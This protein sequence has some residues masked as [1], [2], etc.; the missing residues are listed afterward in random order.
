MATEKDAWYEVT[1][2]TD[3]QKPVRVRAAYV[4]I[5]E[6]L[7]PGLTQLKT[8]GGSVAAL[9]RSDR[10]LMIQREDDPMATAA[11]KP[12]APSPAVMPGARR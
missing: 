12:S 3:P 6:R 7:F 5:D 10:V 9:V 8:E 4:S 1:L 11:V 2:D